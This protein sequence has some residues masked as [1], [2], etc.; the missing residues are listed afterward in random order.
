MVFRNLKPSPFKAYPPEARRVAVE[1]IALLRELPLGFA[2]LLLREITAYD[3]KFPAERESLEQE[4][5]F[6][7]SLSPAQRQ[8]ALAGFGRLRLS[9]ELEHFDWVSEPAQFS[10]RLSAYLWTT[11]QLD[12][13]RAAATEYGWRVDAAKSPSPPPLPRLGIA[14]IGQGA[15]A[16]RRPLFRQLRKQGVYFNAIRPENGLRILLDSV[17]ERAAAHPFPFGHW[18]IDGGPAEPVALSALTVVS[19][20]SLAP[21]RAAVLKKMD[22]VI[23]SGSGGPEVL[24][25]LMVELRPEEI[26]LGG[27]AQEAVLNH[28]KADMLAQGSGTQLYCTSFVQWTAREAL[29]RAHPVTLLARFAPRQKERPLDELIAAP[30]PEPP[31]DPQGSIVD[32]DMGAY[33]TWLNQ[34]RLS[35]AEDAS[36]LVWWEGHPEALAIGPRLPRNTQ[37]SNSF[38]MRQLLQQI[39]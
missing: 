12:A 24:H 35:G 11:H 36:F 13:F 15:A 32:A 20:R 19:Y 6:L 33:L 27:S 5:A 3:W 21:Q 8:E 25:N 1:H 2:P 22:K 23:Q 7:E 9:S 30:Q 39:V 4:L 29:R 14:V 34:Q 18:Y 28:F 10:T 31:L 37:S 26:G 17:L 38:D 16:A